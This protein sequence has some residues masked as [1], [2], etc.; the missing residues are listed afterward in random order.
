MTEVQSWYFWFG[1][2]ER[3]TISPVGE[4]AVL[5]DLDVPIGTIYLGASDLENATRWINANVIK[6]RNITP[7]IRTFTRIVNR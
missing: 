2:L 7:I 4:G 1:L 5:V 6:G 3:G